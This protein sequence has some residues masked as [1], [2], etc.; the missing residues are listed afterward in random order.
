MD[1]KLE[2]AV[3]FST[4]YMDDEEEVIVM[5]PYR[6]LV[7]ESDEKRLKF[8]D[9]FSQQ[10]YYNC[11][12]AVQNYFESSFYYVR[13]LESLQK[14]YKE[15]DL[16]KL[17]KLY[18]EDIRKQ[19]YY[20]DSKTQGLLKCATPQEFYEET[21]MAVDNNYIKDDDKKFED[22]EKKDFTQSDYDSDIPNIKDVYKKITSCVLC[23][24]K[25]IKKLLTAIYKNIYFNDD[26]LKSNIL[27]YGPTGVGK[28]AILTQIS[29]LLHVP[30]VI[31]DSNRYTMNGYKGSD[32]EDALVNLFYAADGDIELAQHGILVFDEIDKKAANGDVSAAT[33]EGTLNS[34]LK[35]AEGTKFNL[36]LGPGSSIEFDTSHLTVIFS[37]AFSKMKSKLEPET[38]PIG[39]NSPLPK[40]QV[41]G[42]TTQ[43]TAEDFVK[44]GFNPEFIGRINC[45]IGLNSLGLDDIKNILVNSE[46]SPLKSYR[47]IFNQLGIDLNAQ[48]RLIDLIAEK[49]YKMNT[50]ARGLKAIVNDIFENILFDFFSEED[51]IKKIELLPEVLE[52]NSK[53]YQL[54]KTQRKEEKT[55]SN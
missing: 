9:Q 8:Y 52:D 18:M 26:N 33:T 7:G 10:V 47:T 49:A 17:S 43:Y 50:G 30:M 21:G 34:M 12:Y 41:G 1:K 22:K 32:V 51:V 15:T 27:I 24:D 25:Q 3:L 20:F 31:E 13:D 48:T 42:G 14:E 5:Q 23:Q 2:T 19:V 45:F 55:I 36:E 29:K 4:C 16:I 35:I 28:T 46:M 54:V 6:I 38:K 37:G 53:G 11:D 39:F 40:K 44:Y